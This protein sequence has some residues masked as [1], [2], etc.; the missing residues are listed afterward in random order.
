MM[1]ARTR[2]AGGILAR[3]AAGAPS[4]LGMMTA[5]FQQ[6]AGTRTLPSAMVVVKP[7]EPQP[8]RPRGPATIYRCAFSVLVTSRR[9]ASSWA[10]A[11]WLTL[12]AWGMMLVMMKVA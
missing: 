10:Q 4:S 11:F 3:S 6:A 5:I 1:T 8:P 9:E 12:G 7:L 2:V